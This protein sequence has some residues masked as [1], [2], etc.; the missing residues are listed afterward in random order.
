M[1]TWK[2]VDVHH[3]VLVA[4]MSNEGRLELDLAIDFFRGNGHLGS[5]AM[6][7]LEL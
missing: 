1:F 3:P 5:R 6:G 2:V 4:N 7:D